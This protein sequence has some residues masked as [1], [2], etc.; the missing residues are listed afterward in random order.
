MAAVVIVGVRDCVG[1]G[2]P[3]VVSNRGCC[4]SDCV[5]G[6]TESLA[7]ALCQTALGLHG[8]EHA[9]DHSAGHAICLLPDLCAIGELL[10]LVNLDGSRVD[11]ASAALPLRWDIVE[12]L[13]VG[14]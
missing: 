4:G 11:L 5:R 6:Q 3:D 2:L 9:L 12:R 10:E 8:A 7:G 1:D 14:A 13:L